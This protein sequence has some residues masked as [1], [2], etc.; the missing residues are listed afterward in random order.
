MKK[1]Y[2][3]RWLEQR[4]D[5]R[6]P[7]R[8]EHIQMK[9]QLREKRRGAAVKP[10]MGIAECV[11]ILR[12]NNISK[13]EKVLGA[14]IQAGIFPEWSKPSVGTKELCPDISR[15][16]FMEWVK[17]FYKLEKVYTKEDPKE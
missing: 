15:A 13:T 11:Q 5:A 14:Q 2:N 17:D 6:Q 1:H 4:L 9:R 3:K 10:S 8:L 12:D 16:R 7:E